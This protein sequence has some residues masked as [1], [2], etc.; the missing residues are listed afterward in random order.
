MRFLFRVQILLLLSTA[1]FGQTKQ[2][3]DSMKFLL[4]ELKSEKNKLDYF[5]AHKTSN[6]LKRLSD[7]ITATNQATINDYTDHFTYCPVYFYMDTNRQ[8][9]RDKQFDDIIFKGNYTLVPANIIPHNENRFLVVKFGYADDSLSV[10]QN[11]TGLV[12]YNPQLEQVHFIKKIKGKVLG[13][14][15]FT[16]KKY[17]IEYRPFATQLN[18]SLLNRNKKG[19]LQTEKTH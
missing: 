14:Y 12:M 1:A 9:I 6:D 11:T 5:R 18:N 16:S 19:I 3:P 10:F 2:L 17:N 4:V 15:Y 8:K 13:K 7:D